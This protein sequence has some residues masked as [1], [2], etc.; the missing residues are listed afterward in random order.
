MKVEIHDTHG[1]T[2]RGRT[3]KFTFKLSDFGELRTR[4]GEPY[5]VSYCWARFKWNGEDWDSLGFRV[6]NT[7]PPLRKPYP[8]ELIGALAGSEVEARALK[9]MGVQN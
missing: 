5:K 8:G 2:R 9:A 6:H 1:Y 7:Y 4:D 3:C